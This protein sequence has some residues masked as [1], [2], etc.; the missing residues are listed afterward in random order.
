[1]PICEICGGKYN[2]EEMA[3]D[4]VCINCISSALQEDNIDFWVGI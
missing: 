2:I 4:K 1:M 3:T